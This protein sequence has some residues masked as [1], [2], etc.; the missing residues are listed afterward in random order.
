VVEVDDT[1]VVTVTGGK[2]TTYRRMAADTVDA[3]MAHRGE[4]RRCRTRRLRLR[5]TPTPVGNGSNDEPGTHLEGRYGSEVGEVSALIAA[6]P[7]LADPLVPG[8]AYSRAEAVHAV[9][10]EMAQTLD[11][12]LSRRTRARLEDRAATLAT[13]ES[14]AD[15][16]G[17]EAGWSSQRREHEIEAFRAL[18]SAED[19][20]QQGM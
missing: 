14:V 8:L 7:T 9:R 16:V 18:V 1:G 15:L 20:A 11:D 5:G 17:N 10:C 13:V 19:E 6:D 3:V 2:L 12:V 4:S